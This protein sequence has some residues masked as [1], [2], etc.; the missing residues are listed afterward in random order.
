LLLVL[1]FLCGVKC[2]AI[3]PGVDFLGWGYDA[4][5][6][7]RDLFYSAT[8]QLFIYTYNQTGKTYRYPVDTVDYIVPDQ[9]FV[10]TVGKT[11]TD[12]YDFDDTSEQTL[13]LD[14]RVDL[15]LSQPK[16][17]AELTVDFD[18]VQS[19]E[20]KRVICV[21][22]AETSLYQLYLSK[23]NRVLTQE[24]L[25]AANDAGAE[26]YKVDPTPYND[27]I[28]RFG[29]HFVESAVLGGYVQQTT[30]ISYS[31]DTEKLHLAVAIKGTFES[32]TTTVDGALSLDFQE[33]TVRVQTESTSDTIVIGGDTDFSDFLAN[34]GDAQG[35]QIL[36]QSWKSTLPR[37][38]IS[39]RYRLKEIFSLFVNDQQ[40]Y[41]EL[42]T[43]TGTALG[44][45]PNEDKD[46]CTR[47]GS[48]VTVGTS[49]GAVIL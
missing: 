1:L 38:P 9:V 8:Q 4:T 32:G 43:A 15:K 6:L 11:T 12:S 29:T 34:S 16:I 41:T 18:V 49:S 19:A 31:N 13:T 44:Y 35:T 5:S 17:N 37:N 33:A 27:F 40:F 28:T 10:R 14:L 48:S 47:G 3:I 46:Y 7:D 26:P 23:G 42:C 25:D 24:L 20:D 36:F 45:L 22:I 21:N 39:V 30:K 2:G